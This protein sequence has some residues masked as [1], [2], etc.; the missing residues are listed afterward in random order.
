MPLSPPSLPPRQRLLN[1]THLS[2]IPYRLFI[3][4]HLEHT[5]TWPNPK[6]VTTAD[7]LAIAQIPTHNALCLCLSLRLSLC[8]SLKTPHTNPVPWRSPVLVLAQ[9]DSSSL[10]FTTHRAI[11]ISLSSGR[12]DR[13]PPPPPPS[14]HHPK[15]SSLYSFRSSHY[16]TCGHTLDSHRHSPTTSLARHHEVPCPSRCRFSCHR[17]PHRGRRGPWSRHHDRCVWPGL[18]RCR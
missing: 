7:W 11:H 6:D 8:L 10:I 17:G 2:F 16:H 9:S 18:G 12:L 5:G 1:I 4:T 14:L 13:H 3:T 15:P